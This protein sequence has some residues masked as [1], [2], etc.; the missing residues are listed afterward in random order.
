VNDAD[1]IREVRERFDEV[2]METSLETV[3]SRGRSL[4]R[5]KRL[6]G[7]AAA[8]AAAGCIALAVAGI[9]PG[10][11]PRATLAAWTVTKKPAGIVAVSIRQ[12]SNPAGLQH[13]LREDGVPATVR[14]DGQMYPQCL[15]Y[16]LT[17]PDVLRKIFLSGDNG[18]TIAFTINPAAIPSG[19][20]LWIQVIPQ[21]TNSSGV[22]SSGM[23]A[24][25]VYAS[26]RCPAPA[27]SGK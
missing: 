5:R 2:H 14:F 13:T 6:P 16:P 27:K 25:L 22:S 26:G 12:L 19:A 1:V 23:G 24:A 17:S 21:H 15:T 7:I 8:A 4:R 20:A 9:L 11:G 18:A 10:T 3:V